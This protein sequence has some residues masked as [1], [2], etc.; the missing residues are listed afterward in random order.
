MSEFTYTISEPKKRLQAIEFPQPDPRAR[1]RRVSAS[2]TSESKIFI[3][4]LHNFF[5][6]TN[7]ECVVG[8]VEKEDGT[9]DNVWLECIKF[10]D[11][12]SKD[13]D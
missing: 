2:H 3:G 5:Y 6:D 7:E 4:W 11:I 8:I 9:L 13:N 10:I 12:P 1:L